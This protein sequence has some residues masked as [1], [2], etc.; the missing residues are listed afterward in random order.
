MET[1]VTQAAASIS[2]KAPEDVAQGKPRGSR[3]Q[4]R[5]PNETKQPETQAAAPQV[6]VPVDELRKMLG[7][8]LKGIA[9]ATKT[10][11]P[12]TDEVEALTNSLAHGLNNTKLVS[13]KS[14]PWTL[15][16][17]ASIVYTVPRILEVVLRRTG[18]TEQR[19]EENSAARAATFRTVAAAESAPEAAQPVRET[20]RETDGRVAAQT[21][22]AP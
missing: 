5:K 3:R 9:D 6:A 20:A 10:R 14:G 4:Q 21:T 13:E 19:T 1:E 15:F 22:F 16:L 18:E 11:Q 17:L 8:L 7:P 12:E 2:A